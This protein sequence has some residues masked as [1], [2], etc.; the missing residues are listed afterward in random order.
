MLLFAK[1]FERYSSRAWNL[2]GPHSVRFYRILGT[3]WL[4]IAVVLAIPA[5]LIWVHSGSR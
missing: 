1:P 5:I 3:I 4:L 2:R